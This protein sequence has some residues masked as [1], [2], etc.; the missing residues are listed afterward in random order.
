MDD[1]LFDLEA[2]RI[3][4]LDYRAFFECALPSVQNFNPASRAA[5][6]SAFTRP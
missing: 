2:L 4:P 6:A 3:D 1:L 5:S